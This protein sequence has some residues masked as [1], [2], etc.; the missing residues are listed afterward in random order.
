MILPFPKPLRAKGRNC[1]HTDALEI[2]DFPF[3]LSL[4]PRC[5]STQQTGHCWMWLPKDPEFLRALANA[6]LEIAK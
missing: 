3:A 6:L 5:I 4:S 1:I 2:I